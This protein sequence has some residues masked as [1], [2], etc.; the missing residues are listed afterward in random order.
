MAVQ[1]VGPARR[2]RIAVLGD[3]DGVHTRSW[4]RWFIERGH[5]VHAVSFYPPSSPLA[6]ATVHALRPRRRPAGQPSSRAATARAA[7]AGRL[8]G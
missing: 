5:D 2:L 8:R 4:V 7:D 3:F 1:P 6:G